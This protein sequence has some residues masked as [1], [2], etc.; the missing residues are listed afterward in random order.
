MRTPLIIFAIGNLI[1]MFSTLYLTGMG[2]REANPFMA[3]LLHSPF[4]LCLVKISTTWLVIW[5]L[6]NSRECRSAR[7]TAWFAAVLYGLISL[8]YLFVFAFLV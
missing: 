5:I 1:D 6:W 3:A 7:K 8:Y 4:L 2:Y